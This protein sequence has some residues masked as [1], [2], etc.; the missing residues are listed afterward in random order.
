MPIL[1]WIGKDKVI[2]HHMDVPYKIL[3]R[4]SGFSDKKQID[5][6]TSSVNA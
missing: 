2:N 4:S 3:E 1:N 6:I 5:K